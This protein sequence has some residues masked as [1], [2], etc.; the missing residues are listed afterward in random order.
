M[1]SRWRR[2]LFLYLLGPFQQHLPKRNCPVSNIFGTIVCNGLSVVFLCLEF[3]FSN[4]KNWLWF[5]IWVEAFNII[6]FKRSI[7]LKVLEMTFARIFKIM[8]LFLK[9]IFSQM[10]VPYLI[11][12]VRE[13]SAGWIITDSFFVEMSHDYELNVIIHRKRIFFSSFVRD[14]SAI[15]CCPAGCSARSPQ[16]VFLTKT[17][18][19]PSHCLSSRI[20]IRTLS[21]SLTPLLFT[22]WKLWKNSAKKWV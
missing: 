20:I 16:K 2:L 18:P 13:R 5:W 6:V 11:S 12:G 8:S 21:L 4:N 3:Y 1:E 10:I 22:V 7:K 14:F 15:F 9:I 17:G 19:F